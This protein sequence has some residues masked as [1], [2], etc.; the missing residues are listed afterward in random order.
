MP[1]CYGHLAQI[2]FRNV[3]D[4]LHA[5]FLK[6]LHCAGMEAWNVADVVIRLGAIAVVKEFAYDRIDA[7][8]PGGEIGSLG[9]GENTE[10]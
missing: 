1:C 10:L 7:M 8:R 3:V 2:K 5:H 4:G 6:L 9:H